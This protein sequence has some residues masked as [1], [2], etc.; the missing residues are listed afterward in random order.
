MCVGGLCAARPAV[1]VGGIP[2][3]VA[4]RCAGSPAEIGNAR[5][6][7][8][9]RAKTRTAAVIFCVLG[10]LHRKHAD[11]EVPRSAAAAFPA[12]GFPPW[13]SV[14]AERGFVT[15]QRSPLAFPHRAAAERSALNP[16][17]LSI[18]ARGTARP[19]TG[20][21]GEA[22]PPVL[23]RCDTAPF[24]PTPNAV[25][26]SQCVP[27]EPLSPLPTSP[28]ALLICYPSAVVPL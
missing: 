15:A 28:P 9:G 12:R 8:E 6:V 16:Q 20:Q 14:S 25:R 19:G 11:A 27:P 17:R 13:P 26:E 24:G 23:Q 7:G 21:E 4:A 1:L 18:A 5:S 3:A 22:D 2:A 10:V